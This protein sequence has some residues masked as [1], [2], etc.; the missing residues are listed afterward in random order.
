MLFN[1][2]H[3]AAKCRVFAE[4]HTIFSILNS[5]KQKLKLVIFFV[6]ILAL[7]LE[8]STLV[9]EYFYNSKS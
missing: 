3:F 4:P 8:S 6:R 1:G 5:T 2:V 9:Y 7:L